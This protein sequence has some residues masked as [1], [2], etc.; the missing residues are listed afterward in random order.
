MQIEAIFIHSI[1]L[2][3][4]NNL[5]KNAMLGFSSFIIKKIESYSDKYSKSIAFKR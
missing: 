3:L 1:C 5:K 2:V 4:H